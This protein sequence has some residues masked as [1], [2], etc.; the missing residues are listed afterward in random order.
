MRGNYYYQP[1][2]EIDVILNIAKENRL[3]KNF[4]RVLSGVMLKKLLVCQEINAKIKNKYLSDYLTERN[5]YKIIK[6]DQSILSIDQN[7]KIQM[8]SK[9]IRKADIDKIL[10]VI[11]KVK[12]AFDEKTIAKERRT[13]KHQ[14]VKISKT[15][16]QLA[17]IGEISPCQFLF[18]LKYQY[19]RI[20]NNNLLRDTA[21]KMPTARINICE[22]S[23]EFNYSKQAVLNAKNKLIDI[24]LLNEK[25]LKGSFVQKYGNIFYD[26]DLIIPDVYKNFIKNKKI[27]DN[28]R[29]ESEKIDAKNLSKNVEK[30]DNIKQKT[31]PSY[32]KKFTTHI[33]TISNNKIDKGSTDRINI[34]QLNQ[35]K[36][37]TSSNFEPI[38]NI[39]N[40]NFK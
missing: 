34:I 10:L 4:V 17:V 19:R 7:N 8:E 5:I 26:G 28:I 22:F 31:L 23:R 30:L 20:K 39:L 37:S 3:N 15:F 27:I 21:Y 18:F 14:S 13:R 32:V 36:K 12:I 2:Y 6:A 40:K 11:N 24:L 1:K 9:R 35:E 33:D 38:G 16:L 29:K 25:T